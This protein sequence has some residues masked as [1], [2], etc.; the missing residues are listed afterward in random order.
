V[1]TGADGN[2]V[3]VRGREFVT[4]RRNSQIRIP[5]GGEERSIIQIVQDWGSA[6]FDIGKQ[7]DPHFGVKT[8]YLAA[9]VK[10][11]M[12]TVTVARDGASMQVLEGAVEV[13]TDD[14]GARDLV[15]HGVGR[16]A[17]G[18]GFECIERPRRCGTRSDDHRLLRKRIRGLVRTVG[19][20]DRWRNGRFRRGPG[21]GRGG[22]CWTR[23][24]TD[25]ERDRGAASRD[26]DRTR[27]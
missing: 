3:L 19:R 21:G 27:A 22:S 9:V 18:G 6:L 5:A 2:A 26:P 12:F 10:G 24:C 15:R 11:T 7:P 1:T 17:W 16:P 4:V 13:S 14:G 20:P 25:T 23:R 8:E